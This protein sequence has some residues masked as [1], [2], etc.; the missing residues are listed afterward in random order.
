MQLKFKGGIE[1]SV[2][3]IHPR[4]LQL[5]EFRDIFEADRTDH[6]GR[7]NLWKKPIE[8]LNTACDSTV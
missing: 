8:M 1:E 7:K 2:I 3:P 5:H 6:I 4:G